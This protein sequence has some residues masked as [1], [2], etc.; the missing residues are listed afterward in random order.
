MKVENRRLVR[1]DRVARA[2]AKA[3]TLVDCLYAPRALKLLD[4]L[5]R[6][7]PVVSPTQHWAI[8]AIEVEAHILLG[9]HQEAELRLHQM[10]TASGTT[11][12]HEVAL[13]EAYL[14]A[15]QNRAR[16]A[17]SRAAD[18][19]RSVVP[20]S[21][22]AARGHWIA[23][24]ALYRAG[25]YAWAKWSFD[26]SA[27]HYRIR[28][29]RVKLSRVLENIALVLKNQGNSHAALACLDEARKLFPTQ[30]YAALRANNQLHRGICFLRLGQTAAARDSL[31]EAQAVAAPAGQAALFSAICSNL[32]HI[33]RMEGNHTTAAEFYE[34][35]LRLATTSGLLRQHALALEFLA[36]IKTEQGRGSEALPL[37][38]TALNI[39][40]RLA[41]HGDLTMEL[42]RRRGEARL[43]IGQRSD[44][45]EDLSRCIALCRSRG[46]TRER[47]LAERSFHL[48]TEQLIEATLGA[49]RDVLKDL[50]RIGDRFEFARTVCLLVEDERFDLDRLAW[51]AEG[52]AA[53]AHYLTSMQLHQWKAR[54]QAATGHSFDVRCAEDGI[55]R[56]A[57]QVS[58][59]T[60]SPLFA[61][62][63]GAARL[64]A[65]SNEPALILGETG[66]G[67]E[68][69]ARL[70]HGS[71]RRSSQPLLG[72]NCG[73]IP[74]HL[75]ESE[76][77]GHVR[78]TFTGADRDRP[79]LFE[80]A[81]GGSVLLDEIGDLPAHVQV[82]LLRFLDDYEA[83][84]VG[85]RTPRRLDV[86]VI[87]ATHKN[88]WQLAEAGA[89]RKDLLYR[90]NVFKV[91]VPALRQRPE[92][93]P[94][95]ALRF[96]AQES[97]DCP[98]M[99]V[100]TD[101]MRWM[102]SYEWPGNVRELRNLCS[103]LR[104]R[105]WGKPEIHVR[106]LPAD[107]QEMC[108]GFLSQTHM[109]PYAREKVALERAQIQRALEQTGGNIS[110]ASRLL[111][112]GRNS[113]ARKVRDYG[114]ERTE[115]RQ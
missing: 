23:G 65:Q 67:K 62:A 54:L 33:Y 41:S 17:F 89:F 57:T 13:L 87:A 11:E 94:D 82:T 42:L 74:E 102:Q 71:G 84:R 81:N 10:R 60:R 52:R 90:L 73:A 104:V 16:A 4:C 15:R 35:T 106:D 112:M 80:T 51:L 50:Q 5:S 31:L 105:C 14:L 8:L 110:R 77:F 22:Q 83:R 101:L 100:S 108:T 6:T 12:S 27:A 37:L 43:S 103:Y 61:Q 99:R 93:I 21:D 115:I 9:S 44:G 24:L 107:Y 86:R 98:A 72:I 59:E 109:S 111:G 34:E 96:L 68:V 7:Y 3:R 58:L 49:M 19:I 88:L 25:H 46:E 28:R 26:L 48:A 40:S 63:L 29:E 66:A 39:S 76:L 114:I 38:E 18:V 75:V 97:E 95:L 56:D 113:L 92:D 20:T 91:D 45:L 85:D 70:I 1:D 30:R 69:I 79:G 78:G 55:R 53:A 32:G 64:A 2:I 36:E 47:I